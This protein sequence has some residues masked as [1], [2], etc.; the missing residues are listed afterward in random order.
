MD[1]KYLYVWIINKRIIIIICP[2]YFIPKGIKTYWKE[3]NALG[4]SRMVKNWSCILPNEL[5]KQTPLKHLTATERRWKRKDVSRG[6]SVIRVSLWPKAEMNSE[7]TWFIGPKVSKA[8]GKKWRVRQ[9]S[10]YYYYYKYYY[11]LYLS[12]RMPCMYTIIW[13]LLWRVD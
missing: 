4:V 3:I 12:K 6:P 13:L 1:L 9:I 7:P 10:T 5:V 11:V 8:I 2:R